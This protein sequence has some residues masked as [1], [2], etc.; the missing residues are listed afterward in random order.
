[1]NHFFPD[2]NGGRQVRGQIRSHAGT[3]LMMGIVA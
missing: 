3:W 1:M 2:Q